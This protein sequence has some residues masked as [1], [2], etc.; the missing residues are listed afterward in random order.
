MN[1]FALRFKNRLGKEPYKGLFSQKPIN[2]F[3]KIHCGSKVF[4]AILNIFFSIKIMIT[5]IFATTNF[6]SKNK[7]NAFPNNFQ[8]FKKLVATMNYSGFVI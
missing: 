1:I 2:K 5:N 4:L 3:T 6:N 7:N 8:K